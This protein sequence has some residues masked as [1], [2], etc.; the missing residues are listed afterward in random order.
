MYWSPTVSESDSVTLVQD[1]NQTV[2]KLGMQMLDQGSGRWVLAA[3]T[4]SYSRGSVDEPASNFSSRRRSDGRN[5]RNSRND[6]SPMTGG[7]LPATSDTGADNGI[8]AEAMAAPDDSAPDAT[9]AADDSSAAPE[10]AMTVPAGPGGDVLR[11][12]M[13]N[14]ARE[15]QQNGTGN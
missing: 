5:G 2:M 14:R 15:E 13:E 9:D 6:F 8:P 1:T 11:I 12:L 7:I 10:P 3:N 4:A